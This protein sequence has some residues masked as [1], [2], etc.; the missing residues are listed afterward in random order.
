LKEKK[1]GGVKKDTETEVEE[2]GEICGE[3]RREEDLVD[4]GRGK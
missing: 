3:R 2:T 4:G 1:R